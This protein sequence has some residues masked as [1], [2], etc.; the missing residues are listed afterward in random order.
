MSA[1]PSLPVKACRAEALPTHQAPR[2]CCLDFLRRIILRLAPAAQICSYQPDLPP[3]RAPRHCCL[4]SHPR[5]IS[6]STPGAA[7]SAVTTPPPAEAPN[8]PGC[9]L[10]SPAC[11]SVPGLSSLPTWLPCLPCLT[12]LPCPA[13]P[14]WPVTPCLRPS[15]TLPTLPTF[16][17]YLFPAYRFEAICYP[18]YPA[19]LPCLPAQ[20]NW[21]C[22]L[23]VHCVDGTTLPTPPTLPPPVRG[24]LLPCLPYLLYALWPGTRALH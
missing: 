22:T 13:Y 12:C 11:C 9:Q 17:T 18:N 6:A 5:C 20:P 4:E 21:P 23:A 19:Y 14:A 1:F 7:A 24:H 15:A 2:A 10:L 16:P 8:L 3:Y